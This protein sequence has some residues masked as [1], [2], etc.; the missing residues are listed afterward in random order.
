MSDFDFGSYAIIDDVEHHFEK[1]VDW[2]WKITP[3]TSGDELA[4][5]KFL[6]QTRVEVDSSGT[7]REFPP[8]YTEIAYREIA[9]CFGGTTIPKGGKKGKSVA[10]GGDPILPDN[11]K[12]DL[13]EATLRKMPHEMV[14]E[15][16]GAIAEAVPGWGP[17]RPKGMAKAKSSTSPTQSSG[18][19]TEETSRKRRIWPRTPFG[20]NPSMTLWSR[21][22]SRS[23][24][25][26]TIPTERC[27][28]DC[29]SNRFS[30]ANTST[31]GYVRLWKRR[32]PCKRPSG[33]TILSTKN[34]GV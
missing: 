3:P 26:L 28:P 32:E 24:W 15:I 27:F 34:K 17:Q 6:V 33:R 13:I 1:E 5:S 9:L 7:R 25:T 19:D 2:T 16:W 14:M 30:S 4:M 22:W 31:Y 18:D 21:G 29:C 11:A 23:R 8:T 12:I 20:P 10:E